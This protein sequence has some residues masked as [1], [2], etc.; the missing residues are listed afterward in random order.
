MADLAEQPVLELQAENEKSVIPNEDDIA[1]DKTEDPVQGNDAEPEAE[2]K[3]EP[4]AEQAGPEEES[5]PDDVPEQPDSAVV[6]NTM[7]EE[8]N[9]QNVPIDFVTMGMFIIGQ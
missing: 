2:P 6:E 9:Q 8:A 3:T 7:N 5:K 1:L 4:E